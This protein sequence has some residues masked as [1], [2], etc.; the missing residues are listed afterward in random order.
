MGAGSHK[1][2]G[3]LTN[4]CMISSFA[5][6]N[7]LNERISGPCCPAAAR[8]M[9]TTSSITRFDNACS[10]CMWR[11]HLSNCDNRP[12]NESNTMVIIQTAEDDVCILSSASKPSK[13]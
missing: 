7:N 1:T 12:E 10:S 2:V 13:T 6:C 5:F 9:R 3:G 8:A 11:I 4:A